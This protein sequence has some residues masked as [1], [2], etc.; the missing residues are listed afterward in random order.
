MRFLKLSVSSILGGRCKMYSKL[1]C[2]G[3]FFLED[4]GLPWLLF[5]S[6][7]WGRPLFL[8]SIGGSLSVSYDIQTSHE[9][10]WSGRGHTHIDCLRNMKLKTLF[11]FLVQRTPSFV[12]ISEINYD[13]KYDLT[14]SNETW[15]L[16]QTTVPNIMA[17]HDLSANNAPITSIWQSQCT[18]Y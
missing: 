17:F 15:G 13:N 11:M 7:C 6:C 16:L 2:T 10:R 12:I 3:I 14:I 18:I 4:F 1:T 5:V 9:Y 8:S